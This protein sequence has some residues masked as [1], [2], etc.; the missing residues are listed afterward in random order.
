M[1]RVDTT[2][3]SGLRGLAALHIM[4]F[5]YVVNYTWG[6]LDI[7][8]ALEVSIFFLLSGFCLTLKYGR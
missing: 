1:V 3:T 6:E 5:H 8:G 7:N 2:A 4:M